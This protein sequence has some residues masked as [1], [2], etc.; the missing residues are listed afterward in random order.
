M[1]NADDYGMIDSAFIG[2]TGPL[3]ASAPEVPAIGPMTGIFARSLALKDPWLD[4]FDDQADDV[5]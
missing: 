5:I 3:A 2:Q 1:I 4:V